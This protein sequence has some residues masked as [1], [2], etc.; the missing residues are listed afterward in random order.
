MN[1][2]K[3]PNCGEVF[4]IDESDYE[5]IVKQIKDHEYMEDLERVERQHKKELDQAVMIAKADA[6]KAFTEKMN[7]K[8][9]EIAKL[10]SAIEKQDSETR[11]AVSEAVKDAELAREE[12]K[13]D[14][15][16]LIG[17]KDIEI[18]KLNAAIEKQN[19][20]SQLAINEAVKEKEAE[21]SELEAKSRAMEESFRTQL[22]GKDETIAFY[23]DLK[24]K[25]STKMI[26][27]SLEQH[28]SYEFNRLR[29]T[30]FKNA[31]FE[32]DNDASSGSKGDF[33][34]RDYGDDGTEFISIMFEMKNESDTTATKHKNEHFFKELDKDRNEKKC[35]YAIL[36]SM[37]E[38]DNDLYNEGIVDVS[39]KYPKMYVIRPQFFIPIITLLRDAALNSLQYRKELQTVQNQNLDY[40]KFE[41][42]MKQFKDAFGRNYEL[43]SR[44]FKDAIDDIDRT[45]KALE[46]TKADLL[47]SENNLR[48]ANDKAQDLSIKKLTKGAPSVAEKFRQEAEEK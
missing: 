35:E 1:Q 16:E 39:Y 5:S 4:T 34:F 32:K 26:G 17:K 24:A 20:Q 11:L 15:S 47:S 12:L 42:N 33:I 43:A 45:I 31:Y 41:E 46:K 21:I 22:A 10:N 28:C 29:A 7:V 36:V 40:A 8:D 6:E 2:I 37:L 27:E 23:K 14:L 13:R 9:L 18:A 30:A 38:A 25:Q 48:L 19:A 3:C 44:K